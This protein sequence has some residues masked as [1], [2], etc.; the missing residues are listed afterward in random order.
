MS[1]VYSEQTEYPDLVMIGYRTVSIYH[2]FK[3]RT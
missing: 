2:F 3:H 1:V